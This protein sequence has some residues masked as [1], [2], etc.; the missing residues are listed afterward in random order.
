MLGPCF[1]PP[2]A[3]FQ[4][5]LY[6]LARCAKQNPK[7]QPRL[8]ERQGPNLD[9][10]NPW[11]NGGYMN[12]IPFKGGF[13]PKKRFQH[14]RPRF[15]GGTCRLHG[16]D[17]SF[18][19]GASHVSGPASCRPSDQQAGPRAEGWVQLGS[20]GRVHMSHVLKTDSGR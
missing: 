4:A 17:A 6:L 1:C 5:S 20:W 13:T 2:P 9:D 10:D 12:P 3:L 16:K 18:I 11:N 19:A 8:K 15:F 7:V 14:I